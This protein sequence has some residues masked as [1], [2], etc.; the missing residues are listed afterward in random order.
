MELSS[1][2]NTIFRVFLTLTSKGNTSPIPVGEIGI[3]LG[4]ENLRSGDF[5]YLN[6]FQS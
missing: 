1:T 5:G 4:D 6:I 2:P 3:L